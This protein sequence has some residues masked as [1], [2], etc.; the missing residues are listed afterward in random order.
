MAHD[1]CQPARVLSGVPRPRSQTIPNR[2]VRLK[3]LLRDAR[4]SSAGWGC[5]PAG[6]AQRLGGVWELKVRQ[7]LRFAAHVTRSAVD[8]AWPAAGG[9]PQVDALSG[10]LYEDCS[11][12][13]RRPRLSAEKVGLSRLVLK[14]LHRWR[15]YRGFDLQSLNARYLKSPSATRV[16]GRRS[17]T[18]GR[19]SFKARSSDA[20]EE[21][22]RSFHAPRAGQCTVSAF[23]KAHF[24]V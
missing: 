14:G 19:G 1:S 3:S 12:Q 15:T 20:G 13:G 22:W 16:S 17:P 9:S 4:I 18:Q 10:P 21:I 8:S 11:S 7:T 2:S 6:F 5:E 24:G 23:E